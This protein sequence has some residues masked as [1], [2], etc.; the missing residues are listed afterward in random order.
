MLKINSFIPVT[1]CGADESIRTADDLRRMLEGGDPLEV[2][3][4]GSLER[5]SSRYK[6]NK[7]KIGK[8]PN[9]VLGRQ[10][11]RV[12]CWCCH[13]VVYVPD[14]GECPICGATN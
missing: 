4:D 7:K 8:V 13:N 14:S 5:Q 1:L 10:G 12:T 11:T 6:S 3:E 9:G 2:K